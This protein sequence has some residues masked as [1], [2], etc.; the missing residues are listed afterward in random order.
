M[1]KV[2][3][4]SRRGNYKTCSWYCRN[5]INQISG[6]STHWRVK[7]MRKQPFLLKR[8]KT[9]ILFFYKN[10]LRYTLIVLVI[11]KWTQ[12][13]MF[14]S[15]TI[16]ISGFSCNLIPIMWMFLLIGFINFAQTVQN[17]RH[18]DN[19]HTVMNIDTKENWRDCVILIYLDR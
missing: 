17:H 1:P 12:D 14:S 18:L 6:N 19:S 8:D 2:N 16:Y 3:S 13:I 15:V 4:Y 5:Q 11:H 9:K 7:A 10:L